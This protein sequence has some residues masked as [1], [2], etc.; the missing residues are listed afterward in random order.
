MTSMSTII[1]HLWYDTQAVEAANFHTSLF[2]R[3][4]INSI[5]KITGT[6][7][8]DCD[9]V[10]FT[11]LGTPMMSISAGPY[12]KLNPAISFFIYSSDKREIEKYWN[13]LT[14]GGKVLM[15]IGKYDWSE[16]YGWVE[17][18]YGVSWQ[19]M[20]DTDSKES[21]VVPSLLFCNQAYGKAGAAIEYYKTIFPMSETLIIATYPDGA[22]DAGKVMYAQVQ[23]GDSKLVLMDGPGSHDFTFNEAI[24][25]IVKCE[26]Q[27]ELDAYWH[28]LSAVPESEQ[29]GWCKDTFGVSWQIVP[30]AMD[31]MMEQGSAEQ[32][33][34]VTQAFLQ[35]K[36]FDI[37]TLEKAYRGV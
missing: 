6:P 9:I 23:L 1:P 34:R 32:R 25:F 33:A 36:K 7:S 17:D 22:P 37:K 13:G 19:L 27:G 12:F 16:L 18:K 8:G 24:S 3:S 11:I 29:C 35:M 5:Q 2:A 30:T 14:V 28:K 20:Y 31:E 26:T 10:S 21:S 15:D 4:K